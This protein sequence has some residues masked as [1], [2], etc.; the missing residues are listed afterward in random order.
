MELDS[1]VIDSAEQGNF[2]D[3]ADKVKVV[4]AQKVQ[5][6]P[7]IQAKKDEYL[8]NTRIKDAFAQIDTYLDTKDSPEE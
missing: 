2:S 4:L 5:N 7:F 6:H 3:F 1:T 8:R